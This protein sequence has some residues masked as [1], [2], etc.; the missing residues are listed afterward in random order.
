MSEEKKTHP[1]HK[2]SVTFISKVGTIMKSQIEL[3]DSKNDGYSVLNVT[4][5]HD[6]DGKETTKFLDTGLGYVN[7]VQ[8]SRCDSARLV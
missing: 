3:I 7:E 1:E 6:S 5:I 4:L 2:Y 8:Y